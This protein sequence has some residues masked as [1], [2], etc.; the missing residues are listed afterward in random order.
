MPRFLFWNYRYSS[1]DREEII[2]SL[3]RE[4][5][6]DVVILAESSVSDNCLASPPQP[7]RSALFTPT[8][9]P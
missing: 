5:T 2:A 8:D 6:V 4:H 7:G 3:V 9:P 1:L